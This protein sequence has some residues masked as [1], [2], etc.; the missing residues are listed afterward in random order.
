MTKRKLGVEYAELTDEGKML[1]ITF[2]RPLSQLET[3]GLLAA[4]EKA[5][6]S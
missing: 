4:I 1:R 5:V 3:S 2:T 6:R